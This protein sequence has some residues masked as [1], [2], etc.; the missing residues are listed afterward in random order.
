MAHPYDRTKIKIMVDLYNIRLYC[1][2]CRMEFYEQPAKKFPSVVG[3]DELDKLGYRHQKRDCGL[4]QDYFAKKGVCPSPYIE[5]NLVGR[6]EAEEFL[7]R[8]KM[9]PAEVKVVLNRLRYPVSK[10]RLS[11]IAGRF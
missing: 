6:K 7:L 8:H 9:K 11:R 4:V 5:A 1:N 10:T 3:M 2:A